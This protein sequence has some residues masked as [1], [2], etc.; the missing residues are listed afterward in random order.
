M[1]FQ[2]QLH[3]KIA[4]NLLRSTFYASSFFQRFLCC[5]IK[6]ITGKEISRSV[7][8]YIIQRH[9]KLKLENKKKGILYKC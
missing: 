8:F 3:Q 2:A 9:Y 4:L 5:L 1:I 6:V 7:Y